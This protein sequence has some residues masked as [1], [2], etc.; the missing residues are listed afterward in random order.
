MKMRHKVHTADLSMTSQARDHERNTDC[1]AQISDEVADTGNLVV[2]SLSRADVRERTYRDKG[3]RQP[4]DLA[5]VHP[6]HGLEVDIWRN[7]H[8]PE[9]ADRG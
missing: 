1:A 5:D 7:V 8:H 2:V 9:L 3:Q 6:N 4:D